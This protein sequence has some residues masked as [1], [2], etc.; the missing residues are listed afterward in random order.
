MSGKTEPIRRSA[1]KGERR[2]GTRSK[3]AKRR[4]VALRR[5]R[6]RKAQR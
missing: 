5:A 6:G 4:A 1:P 2:D 3:R